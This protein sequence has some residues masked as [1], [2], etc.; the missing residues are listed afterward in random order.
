MQQDV[1]TAHLVIYSQVYTDEA[2]VSKLAIA[3]LVVGWWRSVVVSALSSINVVNRHWARLLPAHYYLGRLT[4][5]DND[6]SIWLASKSFLI[7]VTYVLLLRAIMLNNI[8]KILLMWFV[9]YI[10]LQ[11][12]LNAPHICKMCRKHRERLKLQVSSNQL[13]QNRKTHRL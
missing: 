2:S 13:G 11:N 10:E 7:N 6:D 12:F 9:H 1:Q 5:H 3:Q 8:I 4:D